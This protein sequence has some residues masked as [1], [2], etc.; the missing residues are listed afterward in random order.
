MDY[1]RSG[2]KVPAFPVQ[3]PAMRLTLIKRD[4]CPQCGSDLDTGWECIECEFDAQPE[5]IAG[6]PAHP[7]EEKE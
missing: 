2:L 6:S 3:S 4:I 1:I 5:L 7:K